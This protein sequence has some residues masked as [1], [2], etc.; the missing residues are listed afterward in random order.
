LLIV[1][2]CISYCEL[3]VLLAIS[4]IGRIFSMF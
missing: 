3:S 1:A 2:R 4:F